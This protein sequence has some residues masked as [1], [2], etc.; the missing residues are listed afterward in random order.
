MHNRV[1]CI[2]LKQTMVVVVVVGV[3]NNRWQRVRSYEMYI[4]SNVSGPF[5]LL[6][7][8]DLNFLYYS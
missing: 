5:A 1:Y 8:L 4:E 7:S 6:L 2:E 3:W